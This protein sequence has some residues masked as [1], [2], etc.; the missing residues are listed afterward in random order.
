MTYKYDNH[1]ID[2]FCT[3][4]GYVCYIDNDLEPLDMTEEEYV[5]VVTNGILTD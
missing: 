5:E 2:V 1:I 3:I 4:A